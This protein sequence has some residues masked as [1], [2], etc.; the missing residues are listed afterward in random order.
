[1]STVI[2]EAE[3][4]HRETPVRD[5]RQALQRLSWCAV[6][7]YWLGMFY[8]TH[9]PSPPH[10]PFGHA[11]KWMHFS[12]YFGLAVLLSLATSLRRPAS[13]TKSVGIVL[14]LAGYGALDEVTQILVG[15]DCELLDWCADM[16]GV[17]LASAIFWLALVAYRRHLSAKSN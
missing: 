6:A 4:E 12:A 7:V 13:W 10:T 3:I 1:M 9:T 5:Y 2:A 16:V 11:D 8:G 14:L 15:R 17:T